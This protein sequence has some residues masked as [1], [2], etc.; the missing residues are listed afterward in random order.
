MFSS[1]GTPIQQPLRHKIILS[2]ASP[3]QTTGVD[4]TVADT[5]EQEPRVAGLPLKVK[6]TKIFRF[7]CTEF[8]PSGRTQYRVSPIRPG[9][10]FADH[11][12][13]FPDYL[14]AWGPTY[15]L[16]N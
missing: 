5:M 11:Y 3:I 14:A 13:G 1:S 15:Y 7:I 2:P 6:T 10:K 4:K 8:L 9:S 16:R 12:R